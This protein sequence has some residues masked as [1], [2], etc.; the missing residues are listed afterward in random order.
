VVR[1][2][3]FDTK[4]DGEDELS[5]KRTKGFIEVGVNVPAI[6]LA[7]QFWRNFGS[8][9]SQTPKR[10]MDD[11]FLLLAGSDW[12]NHARRK[13]A[14]VRL[15]QISMS[16]TATIRALQLEN[17]KLRTTLER[18]RQQFEEAG[19]LHVRFEQLSSIVMESQLG[20]DSDSV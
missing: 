1:Q 9:W 18:M 11:P 7:M 20:E 17:D 10:T 4:T 12:G 14:I 3:A 6:E 15:E 5:G 19:R 13:R 16:N 2:V 8:F